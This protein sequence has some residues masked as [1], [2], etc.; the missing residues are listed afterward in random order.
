[1]NNKTIFFV[2]IS[3]CTSAQCETFPADYLC[4]NGDK[5]HIEMTGPEQRLIYE[6]T[7][8]GKSH[9]YL[10]VFRGESSDA[11]QEAI[12]NIHG[13]GSFNDQPFAFNF[14]VKV[15][16][17]EVVPGSIEYFYAYYSRG[18][19]VEDSGEC[20]QSKNTSYIEGSKHY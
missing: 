9:G 20:L 13:M 8:F 2:L 16:G 11:G 15:A 17:E 7:K 5:L 19:E 1:M 4:D 6:S 14:S 3:L 18:E 12:A 10:D